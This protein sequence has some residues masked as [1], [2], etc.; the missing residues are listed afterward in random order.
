MPRSFAVPGTGRTGKVH[1]S[2]MALAKAEGPTS[3]SFCRDIRTIQAIKDA[4]DL[5]SIV[6]CTMTDTHAD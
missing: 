4:D 1:A 6:I 3:G 5:D 2:A